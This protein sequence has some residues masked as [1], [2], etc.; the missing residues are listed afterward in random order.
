MKKNLLL[1]LILLVSFFLFLL[2]KTTN[3]VE[4]QVPVITD[5]E[6]KCV[7]QELSEY[8]DTVIEGVGFKSSR[9]PHIKL[10]SPAFNLPSGFETK[11]FDFMLT[12]NPAANFGEL[13]GFA[14]N[15]YANIPGGVG[16]GAYGPG[17]TG[18]Y[19]R[20]GWDQKFKNPN[21]VVFTEYGDFELK[22]TSSVANLAT[23]FKKASNDSK[24]KGILLFNA[25]GSN[26]DPSFQYAVMDPGEINQVLSSEKGG[27]NSANYFDG[28]GFANR[29]ADTSGNAKW[30]LEIATGP[31]DI[32]NVIG[33]IKA[34]QSRGITPIIRLCAAA[35]P[36]HDCGFVDPQ[37]LISFLK[38][39]SS[40]P[41]VTDD[42]YVIT[43]PNEPITERWL[44]KACTPRPDGPMPSPHI[45]CSETNFKAEQT[46][47][48]V[49]RPY[50]ASPCEA[51]KQPKQTQITMMCGN[52]LTVRKSH[53]FYPSDAVPG[54]CLTSG[55]GKSQTCQFVIDKLK[56]TANI[57]IDLSQS[58][59]PIAGNTEAVYNWYNPS[60]N[61]IDERT[62]MSDYVDWYLQGTAYNANDIPLHI[63]PKDEAGIDR[64]VNYTGPINKLMPER[65]F[66]EIK[67]REV[68]SQ[69]QANTHDEFVACLGQIPWS[70]DNSFYLYQ[71]T[72]GSPTTK[73]K[74]LSDFKRN[75]GSDDDPPFE[76]D[77]A[78][79]DDFWKKYKEWIGQYCIQLPT[80]GIVCAGKKDPNA[81]AHWQIPWAKQDDLVGKIEIPTSLSDRGARDFQASGI[82]FV[83]EIPKGTPNEPPTFA[84]NAHKLY[85]PHLGSI[86]DLSRLL[87]STFLPKNTQGW[88]GVES[89]SDDK[90]IKKPGCEIVDTVTNPGDDLFG[91]HNTST[92]QFKGPS[93]VISDSKTLERPDAYTG[94][95][96]QKDIDLSGN[97]AYE[98]SGKFECT[99]ARPVP[100]PVCLDARVDE[101]C[102]DP[103][104]TPAEERSCI[105]EQ[106]AVCTPTLQPCEKISEVTF[107][108]NVS[109]PRIKESWERLVD[110]NASVFKRMFPLITA[111]SPIKEIKDIPAVTSAG[112]YSADSDV[113]A[114]YPGNGKSGASAEIYFPHLGSM[115]EYFLKQ[116]QTALRPKSET[117][118]EKDSTQ[119]PPPT[120]KLQ[121]STKRTFFT[122][123][124]RNFVLTDGAIALGIEAS[125]RTCSPPELILGVL[126]Q[127]TGGK[128][129]VSKPPSPPV[130]DQN[131][132]P[133]TGDPN[134]S[135][136]RTSRCLDLKGKPAAEGFGVLGA[137][138]YVYT[139]YINHIAKY[140]A[141]AAY[142][143]SNLAVGLTSGTVS[144]SPP[145]FSNN[146]PRSIGHAMCITSTKFWVGMR[147]ASPSLPDCGSPRK[148]YSLDEVG[149]V[150]GPAI[151]RALLT[152]CGA[153]AQT[154]DPFI[155]QYKA[156]M[157]SLIAT[158]SIQRIQAEL[159]S[160]KQ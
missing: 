41:E 37:S 114:G 76:K 48:H 60:S 158:G 122:A 50:Q 153:G 19:T 5:E 46:E 63:Q 22:G 147:E 146:D 134:E 131:D 18:W 23:D 39:I 92:A 128:N 15:T 124:G 109:T 14:G 126:A 113:L 81:M 141:G 96:P 121:D 25:L 94:G 32:G 112:Y 45:P 129:W 12:S 136:C 83:P 9:I 88:S 100:D 139:N 59:L 42:V 132:L 20:N 123:N 130:F 36:P 75:S 52:D 26:P 54:S 159:A 47:F 6:I 79:P 90:S 95:Y 110:S 61:N 66:R 143:A 35:S 2:I 117:Q 137:Y 151:R 77:S 103:T 49:Y 105:D 7:A 98:I 80:G 101:F 152:F 8:M 69:A 29:V 17:Q 78:N 84:S 28:G 144:L 57:K 89:A 102:S 118:E 55:D 145:N 30:T 70:L 157:R 86:A 27:I 125:R 44:G 62:R 58:R 104:L 108:V 56:E 142:C 115:Q 111:S 38:E 53:F 67:D 33:S 149:G 150:D 24:I 72:T 99:F 107:P 64:L 65:L 11:L 133:I 43:G 140:G 68:I 16:I 51:D 21:F 154:C 155:E 106:E 97:V 40:N 120:C 116:I 119:P 82:V 71:C 156:V 74:R 4:A 138:S 34:A 87:Q 1:S 135:V 73:I 93:S 31:G 127:E 13:D 85:M 91:E 3:K 148:S 10:L 160:C